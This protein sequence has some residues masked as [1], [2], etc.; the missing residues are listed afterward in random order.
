MVHVN[1]VLEF[2]KYL[3][4]FFMI[5]IP[6]NQIYDM[7]EYAILGSVNGIVNAEL[8]VRDNNNIVIDVT[9]EIINMQ[10]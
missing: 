4:D 2:V 10:N 7:V 5:Y 3:Y 8:T 1:S 6:D 9:K